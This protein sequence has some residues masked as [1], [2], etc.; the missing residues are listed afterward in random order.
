[1]TLRRA[2]V[3]RAVGVPAALLLGLVLAG[4]GGGSD[5]AP[6]AGPPTSDL[7][8][9]LI[10]YSF[11]LSAGTLR[12]GRVTVTATDA[13]SSQ[14]DVLMTQDGRE[15]GRSRVLSPGQQQTFTVQVAPGEKVKLVCTLPGHAAMGMRASVAVAPG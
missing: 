4:C 6:P 2:P 3:A 10:D 9:G 5:V 7:R 15:I 8:I 1:M 14:H 11:Q 12:P 13:G